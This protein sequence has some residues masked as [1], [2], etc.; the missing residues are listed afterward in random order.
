MYN[1]RLSTS[2]INGSLYVISPRFIPL[3]STIKLCGY[4]NIRSG[5]V[6]HQVQILLRYLAKA[7]WNKTPTWLH[8]IPSVPNVL[9]QQKVPAE[10][11]HQV[12]GL[13][14]R[15]TLDRLQALSQNLVKV[16]WDGAE[17]T[18]NPRYHIYVCVHANSDQ[19]EVT[20]GFRRSSWGSGVSALLLFAIWQN[21]KNWGIDFKFGDCGNKWWALSHHFVVVFE[22]S[23]IWTLLP[24][25]RP[26][27]HSLLPSRFSVKGLCCISMLFDYRCSL[28]W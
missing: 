27:L 24:R 16:S 1:R 12:R 14:L 4:G 26:L 6:R 5:G 19:R 25:S 28:R 13:A 8:C 18:Q 17:N 3:K 11:C 21:F 23:N 15:G 22:F 20:F 7:K 10:A 9:W 2:T